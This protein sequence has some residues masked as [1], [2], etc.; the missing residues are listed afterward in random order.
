MN[1]FKNKLINT[2]EASNILGVTIETLNVWRCTKR[3]PLPYVK[4][5]SKVMYKI[6]DINEFIQNQTVDINS[7][8]GV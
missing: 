6:D 2:F 7:F 1:N 4:I 8:K 3:Y 5:G